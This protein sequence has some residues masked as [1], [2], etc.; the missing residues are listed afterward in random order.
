MALGQ[1]VGLQQPPPLNLPATTLTLTLPDA[2]SAV[3]TTTNIPTPLTL[4][5]GHTNIKLAAHP[6]ITQIT[7]RTSGATAPTS[8]R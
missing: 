1:L 8:Q 5:N 3:P 4:T 6:L 7:T 2:T